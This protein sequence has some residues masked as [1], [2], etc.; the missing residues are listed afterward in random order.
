MYFV[1][2]STNNRAGGKTGQYFDHCKS[3]SPASVN[4]NELFLG[5]TNHPKSAWFF[6]QF[7]FYHS[8]GTPCWSTSLFALVFA[9]FFSFL[10]V[11]R[12]TQ[13]LLCFECHCHILPLPHIGQQIFVDL[14]ILFGMNA[15]WKLIF[16][17]LP[18]AI[19]DLFKVAW[20]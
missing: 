20:R 5:Q 10:A 3:P 11:T 19:E 4:E 7:A 17:F 15:R 14:A 16:D 18:R 8:F 13:S 12:S 9:C 1:C 6:E 2:S